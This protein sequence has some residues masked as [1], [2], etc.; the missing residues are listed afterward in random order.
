M[1]MFTLLWTPTN[2]GKIKVSDCGEK[3]HPKLLIAGRQVFLTDDCPIVKALIRFR[4]RVARDEGGRLY[5]QNTHMHG[6]THAHMHIRMF[7]FLKLWE[8]L[9]KCTN[10]QLT[11]T[12]PPLPKDHILKVL[13]I[14]QLNRW[15]AAYCWWTFCHLQIHPLTKFSHY[16]DK[17]IIEA[18]FLFL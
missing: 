1:N 6:C 14:R 12:A 5:Q 17:N 15:N 4:D 16:D 13:F 9:T 11:F 2:E 18:A 8:L 7:F 10:W 3:D